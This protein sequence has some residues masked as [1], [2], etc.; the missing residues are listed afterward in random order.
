MI[1]DAT[2][3]EWERSEYPWAAEMAREIRRLREQI[4]PRPCPDHQER[5]CERCN[6]SGFRCVDCTT[7]SRAADMWQAVLTE[8]K[9]ALAAHQ[10]VVRRLSGMLDEIDKHLRQFWQD[11][12]GLHISDAGVILQKARGIPLVV[13]ARREGRG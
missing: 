5:D 9:A 2:L 13:A 7:Y 8:T 1:D 6:G 11:E 12:D 3:A 4:N 10:A